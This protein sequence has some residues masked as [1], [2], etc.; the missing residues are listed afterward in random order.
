MGNK[1]HADLKY[2]PLATVRFRRHRRP[3][4]QPDVLSADRSPANTPQPLK[5]ITLQLCF[6]LVAFP[7]MVQ[8][9][10]PC[11]DLG[12]IV[13]A[14]VV[15]IMIVLVTIIVMIICILIR[16]KSV[17]FTVPEKEVCLGVS[18]SRA[19]AVYHQVQSLNERLCICSICV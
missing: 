9:K 17:S 5:A 14:V 13:V 16:I 18:R 11:N 6:T 7:G 10:R 3:A 8:F 12:R 1:V 4:N 15:I 2:E 19:G